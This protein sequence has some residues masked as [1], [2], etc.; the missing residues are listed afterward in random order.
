MSGSIPK[1]PPMI[2]AVM[3]APLAALDLVVKSLASFALIMALAFSGVLFTGVKVET[4]ASFYGIFVACYTFGM[5]YQ[6]VWA[7]A[8]SEDLRYNSNT[9]L[10][11]FGLKPILP[12]MAWSPGLC[13]RQA[14]TSLEPSLFF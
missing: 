4:L 6:M 14:T 9:T 11:S 1:L 10:R 13:C 7:L 12:S 5:A 2:S 8:G 3:A